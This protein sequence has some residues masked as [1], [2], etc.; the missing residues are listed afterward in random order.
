MGV[1]AYD[2]ATGRFWSV[3]P[4]PGG[5]S[6]AY[7]YCSGDPVNCTDLDGQISKKWKKRFGKIGRIAEYGSWIPGP[8]GTASAAISAGAY[9]A[10]GNR[11]KAAVMGV[12]AAANLVGAGAAVKVGMKVATRAGKVGRVSK[13]AKSSCGLRN[14]FAADTPV[15]LADGTTIPIQDVQ[16]GDLVRATDPLTGQASPQPVLA[17]ITGHGDKHLYTITTIDDAGARDRLEDEIGDLLFV[18]ANLARHAKVDVGSA[19]RRA[20]LKFE[21]RF[22][23]MEALARADGAVLED[24]P[25]AAHEAYWARA[26]QGE[27]TD[28]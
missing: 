16:I 26:K 21:R 5:N 18:V 22:R 17:T 2:P 13:A 4:T 25:L 19:L 24:L 10:S 9:A 20:N 28:R 1:R 27:G 8:I 11:K 3:D 23:A 7:D 6:T 12:T 15:L 14:S